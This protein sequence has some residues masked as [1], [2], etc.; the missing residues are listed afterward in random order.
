MILDGRIGNTIYEN[1]PAEGYWIKGEGFYDRD[2]HERLV[3]AWAEPI[4]F[5]EEE[6]NG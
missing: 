6:T 4:P 3:K 1:A 2:A 5:E